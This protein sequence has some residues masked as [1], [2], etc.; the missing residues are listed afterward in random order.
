MVL[1]SLEKNIHKRIAIVP[2]TYLSIVSNSGVRRN[3]IICEIGLMSEDRR[4]I[5]QKFVMRWAFR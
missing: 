2:N 4:I 3:P 1:L 5:R